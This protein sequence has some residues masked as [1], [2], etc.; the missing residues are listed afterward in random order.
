[1]SCVTTSPNDARLRQLEKLA[2]SIRYDLN[3]SREIAG[4]SESAESAV[5]FKIS[6]TYSPT[7]TKFVVVF[8][9]QAWE[10]YQIQTSV[11]GAEWTVASMLVQGAAAPAL[12]T[13]W[14]SE[15]YPTG[16]VGPVYFRV[17]RYPNCC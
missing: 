13:T 11:D 9:S 3:L 6:A 17:R 14:Y 4:I 1:M 5:V 10:S 12:T 8:P 16:P 15:A 2:A 7:L